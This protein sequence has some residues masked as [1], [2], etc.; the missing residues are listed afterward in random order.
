MVGVHVMLAQATK[1]PEIAI[2]MDEGT[3]MLKAAQNVMRHYNVQ[4]TQKTL[5]WISLVG[6]CSYVYV[7]RMIAIAANKKARTLEQPRPIVQPAHV[8]T[9]APPGS[10]T[11][12]LFA[13]ANVAHPE[14]GF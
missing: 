6:V 12:E 2:T 14:D 9:D 3:N 13:M 11:E 10:P 8:A 5:D 7:P 1:T 4:S